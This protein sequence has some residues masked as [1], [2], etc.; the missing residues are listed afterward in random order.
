MVDQLLLRIM[1]N[2]LAKTFYCYDFSVQKKLNLRMLFNSPI[3]VEVRQIILKLD[4][5]RKTEIRPEPDS[6]RFLIGS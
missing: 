4:P 5:N 2:F 3:S 1:D 6:A